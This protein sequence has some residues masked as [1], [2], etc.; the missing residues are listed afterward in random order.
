MIIIILISRNCCV[1][2]GYEIKCIPEILNIQVHLP[3]ILTEYVVDIVYV[4]CLLS[5]LN[6]V[7]PCILLFVFNCTCKHVSHLQSNPFPPN[8]HQ[9]LMTDIKL[10]NFFFS[11]C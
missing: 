8:V 5:S 2:V 6:M 9:F 4:L 1:K 3:L 7:G 10:K 11:M